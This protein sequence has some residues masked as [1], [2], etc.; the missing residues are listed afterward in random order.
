MIILKKFSGVIKAINKLL[1]KHDKIYRDESYMINP[2]DQT[3][4]LSDLLFT[5]EDYLK[6][7]ATKF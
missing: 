6:T 5:Q 3:D 7:N 1:G 4:G 2:S